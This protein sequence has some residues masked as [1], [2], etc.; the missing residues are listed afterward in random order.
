M[1][2]KQHIKTKINQKRLKAFPIPVAVLLEVAAS[3]TAWAA[4]HQLNQSCQDDHFIQCIQYASW[5]LSALAIVLV[6]VK[7]ADTIKAKKLPQ[8]CGLVLL[9]LMFGA[10]AFVVW[11]VSTFCIPSF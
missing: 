10:A 2:V 7:L 4:S 5:V 9:V 11:L 8:S 6:L 3:L 1:T